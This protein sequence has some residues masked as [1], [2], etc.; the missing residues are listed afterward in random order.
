MV[1][2]AVALPRVRGAAARG[3]R[4]EATIDMRRHPR[5]LVS[6]RVETADF[7][8]GGLGGDASRDDVTLTGD[9]GALACG[10]LSCAISGHDAIQFPGWV[11]RPQPQIAT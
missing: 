11:P 6:E 7:G 4:L 10:V 1:P 2:R 8:R 9:G 5:N 3:G